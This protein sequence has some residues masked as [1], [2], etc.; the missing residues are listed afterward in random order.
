MKFQ[1][2]S[3]SHTAVVFSLDFYFLIHNFHVSSENTYLHHHHQLFSIIT[4]IK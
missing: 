3:M 1:K 2:N 4:T